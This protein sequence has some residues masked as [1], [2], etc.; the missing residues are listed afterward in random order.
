MEPRSLGYA[1]LHPEDVKAE[2]RKQFGSVKNFH[3][4]FGLS[5]SG[6]FDVLRGRASKPVEQALDIVLEGKAT[7]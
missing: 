5:R 7:P 3:D 2:I 6:V 4:H 1:G